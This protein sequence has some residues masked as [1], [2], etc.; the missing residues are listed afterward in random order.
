MPL[1]PC[2]PW[3]TS[4]TIGVDD[5]HH[6]SDGRPGEHGEPQV[7]LLQRHPVGEEGTEQHDAVDPEVE[8][9]AALSERLAEGG[10]G[11]RRRQPHGRGDGGDEH[12]DGE[13]LTHA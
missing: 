9:A 13:E 1:I 4:V 5:P 6:G 12:R 7:L 10:E 8:H 2:S 3:K 11:V